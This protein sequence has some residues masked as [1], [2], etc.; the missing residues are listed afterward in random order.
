MRETIESVISLKQFCSM[1]KRKKMNIMRKFGDI[2]IKLTSELK[3]LTYE[4]KT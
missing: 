3:C 4:M 2:K 1:R